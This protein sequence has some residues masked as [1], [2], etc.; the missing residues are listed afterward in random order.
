[1]PPFF[2]SF[3]PIITPDKYESSHLDSG[4]RY[5]F[6]ECGALC[7]IQC[8]DIFDDG[9]ELFILFRRD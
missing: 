6:H 4:R 9:G 8:I 1:M 3:R 2:V 7:V 5:L